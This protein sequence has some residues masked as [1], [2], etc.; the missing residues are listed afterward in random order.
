[1]ETGRVPVLRCLHRFCGHRITLHVP[2]KRG[3]VT[4]ILV[5]GKEIEAFGK[6]EFTF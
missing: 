2:E 4:K 3:K 1:M 6:G 5:A